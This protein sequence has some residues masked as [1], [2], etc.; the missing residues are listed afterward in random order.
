VAEEMSSSGVISDIFSKDAPVPYDLPI[1]NCDYGRLAWVCQ[2]KH[3][4]TD[5]R[6]FY[7][8]DSFNVCSL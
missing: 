8:C 6:C 2:S 5:A 1:P 4:D 3:P 7:T